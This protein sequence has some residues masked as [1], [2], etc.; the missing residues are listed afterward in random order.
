M[1]IL[2]GS[3]IFGMQ[4]GYTYKD[5]NTS[6]QISFVILLNVIFFISLHIHGMR[7]SCLILLAII[8]FV[9]TFSSSL[10][11]EELLV[12]YI[13]LISFLSFMFNLKFLRIV[14]IKIL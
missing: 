1:L 14:S 11:P 12:S 13:P 7:K 4:Y 9:V 3:N 8:S 2:S 6:D 5:K 10:Q